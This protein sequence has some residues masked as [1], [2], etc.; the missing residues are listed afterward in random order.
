M[1]LI[2]TAPS[3]TPIRRGR[4]AGRRWHVDPATA[5]AAALF[6]VVLIADALLIAAAAPKIADLG[7][8]YVNSL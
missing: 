7:A 3:V 2:R 8:L 6:L 4:S 5:I 1:T